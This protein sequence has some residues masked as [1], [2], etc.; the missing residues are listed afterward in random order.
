MKAE[1]AEKQYK[2]GIYARESRDDNEENYE[3]IE[4]QRDLLIDFAQKNRFGE[5]VKIYMD[6]NVS[7]SGFE[8][9]GLDEL[10]EDVTAH[11][12]DLLIAKDLSRL[13][14]NNAKTLLFLDFLE[15][16][17][18]RVITFDGRYDSL[19]DNDTVGIETWFNERYVRDISRKIR[20]NLR[21]KIE[22]GEYIG[23]APYGYI[24]SKEEKNKLCVDENTA[25]VVREIY[26]MY[27]E[28]YGYAYIAKQ[29]NKR[30]YLSPSGKAA[31]NPVA[32]QRIL[33]SRVYVGDT[34]Q[35]VSEKISFK[36]KKTR[37]LPAVRWVITEHTHEGIVSREQFEEAQK[38]RREKNKAAGPHKGRLH[39][40]RGLAYCGGCGSGMFARVR[41]DRPVG[42]I[43]GRYCKGGKSSC[44]SHHLNERAVADVLTEELDRLL[45]NERMIDAAEELF[46]KELQNDN[47]KN[48][49]YRLE[50]QLAS[51][52]RQQEALYMDKLEGKISEQLFM[53]TNRNLEERIS[54]LKEEIEK[55][56][57][58]SA[59][60]PDAKKIIPQ[61][62]EDLKRKGLSR[63]IVKLLVD[64]IL[65]FN[66]GDSGI[67]RLTGLT[68][69]QKKH[70]EANGA[71]VIDFKSE[72][73]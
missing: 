32:V 46:A 6:D 65:V 70:A 19:K 55:L 62:L 39:L 15:E 25:P 58:K 48:R 8:R 17:G 69:E 37:R 12:I 13:G 64:R 41:K 49:L 68:E 27:L 21:Y 60:F 1:M 4:T 11:R 3:T 23:H 38:I 22:K 9:K 35:G 36:S 72:K 31:W 10:K 56:K 54:Q 30:G 51:R 26:G 28:G 20:A 67:S 5:I 14:R 45:N 61:M 18:V 44:E 40:L 43:C 73:I 24:K 29:L 47:V 33:S 42:Y 71:I 63:D 7:G 50:H 34:V 53:R 57:K 66:P 59:Y 52:Q 16:H 2:I